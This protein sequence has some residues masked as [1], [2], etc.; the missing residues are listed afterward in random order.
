MAKILTF[1]RVFELRVKPDVTCAAACVRP[2]HDVISRG[3]P[4][5]HQGHFDDFRS[6]QNPILPDR[7]GQSCVQ[8]RTAEFTRDIVDQDHLV[9]T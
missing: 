2:Q 9:S 7:A 5:R 8:L 1:L 3:S 6:P 4:R